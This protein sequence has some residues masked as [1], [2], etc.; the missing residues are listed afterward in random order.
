LS[1]ATQVLVN[2]SRGPANPYARG[3]WAV[4]QDQSDGNLD[5][6]AQN[7]LSNNAPVIPVTHASLSQ[8]NPRTDGRY[9]VWQARQI[10]GNWD[11]Y[12]DD[13]TSANGPQ[14]LTSTRTLDEVNPAIDWPWVVYQVRSSINTNNPWQL[15]A[16]N[17]ATAQTF[18]VSPST[19]DEIS[20]DVQAG[21]VVWQ[22]F[23]NP[24]AGEIY[25]SSLEKI[26][27][28]R[29]TTNLYGK[30][31]PAIYDNW[32]VWSDNRNIELDI[33]GFDLLRNREFQ[34]TDTPEDETQPYLNGPWLVCMENSQGPL[35]ENA[36]LIHL[37]SLIGVSA[38]RTPTM[39]QWPS[40]AAGQLIWQETVSNQSSI[41]TLPLPALQ[42]V[43]QNQNMVAVGDALVSYAH[44]AFGLLSIWGTNGAVSIT[45]YPSLVPAVTQ[46][47][48][49]LSNGAP[50]G[51]NFNLVAG[52]F[53]LVSFNS[54]RV[55]DLGIN[56]SSSLNLA[57]GVNVFGY[58][59]FPD[60]YS[61]WQL[62]RQLGPGAASSVRMLDA[63]S[64]L[65][66]NAGYSNGSLI[67]EDFP[68]P[69]VAVLML[70]VSSP[71][72]QFIPTDQ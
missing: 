37:P 57:A 4:W 11:V 68:I 71:V 44:N 58:T 60:G 26:Q 43:F 1:G 72:N 33:Y 17:L 23:R 3:Q 36:R 29:L 40:L 16:K 14:A 46:Q 65:W 9:V 54:T 52:T 7:L 51:A 18:Q 63:Q 62:L 55:L 64:G 45:Q 35:T 22:D 49:A 39:K 41:Q 19:Q 34:I 15:F 20:P 6:Y 48:A 24:G 42:P 8:I 30:Y 61:A 13:L 69:N 31:N 27:S 12:L 21:R 32:I 53:L 5:I 38:M 70:Q 28:I 50:S 56:N 25:F 67:G 10:N 59:A 66:R 47:T 2:S